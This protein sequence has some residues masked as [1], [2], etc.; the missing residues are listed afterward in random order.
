MNA[1]ERAAWL[2]ERRTG[3]G[4]SDAPAVCG[5]SRRSSPFG[6]FL[7]KTGQ[8]PEQPMLSHQ[9]WGLL[10]EDAI[11]A[12]YEEATGLTVRKPET[13]IQRHPSRPWM[14]STRDRV[15][16][17][18]ERIVELKKVSAFHAAEW[19]EPGTDEIPREYIIQVHH[20]M[21]VADQAEA[22]VAALIG[23]DDFRIYTVHR[24]K[25]L[26]ERI[27]A[28][29]EDFWARVE[30]REPPEPDWTHAATPDLI[31]AVAGLDPAQTIALGDEALQWAREYSAIS[32]ELRDGAKH[33]ENL[34]ARLIHAMG[35]AATARL[36]DGTIVCRSLVERAGY[37]VEATSYHHFRIKPPKTKKEKA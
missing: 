14:L 31:L 26:A 27:I 4:S 2:A 18:S 25:G 23:G 9:R 32:D 22:D 34:K 24:S 1:A 6:I 16:V 15:C 29:E 36:P 35:E 28:I 33:K 19:G 13:P 20:Q 10:L 17:G 5:V 11:A 3:I 8:L 21:I 30:R 12:A 7:D 37:T